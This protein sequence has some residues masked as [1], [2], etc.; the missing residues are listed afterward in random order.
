MTTACAKSGFARLTQLTAGDLIGGEVISLPSS[1]TMY[2]AARVLAAQLIG[3]APVVDEAGR[4]IGVLGLRDFVN[5]ELDRIGEDV[6]CGRKTN[7]PPEGERLLPCTSVLRFMSTAVQTVPFDA[8]LKR[9]V[10]MMLGGQLHHL[11][12]LNKEAKPI[13]V[14]STLDV[15]SAFNS[16]DDEQSGALPGMP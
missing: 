15:L 10:E 16:M 6:P 1:A 8:P 14:L 7:K 11:V 12:V 2:E 4:C 3:L 5:Y 13:G 9:V